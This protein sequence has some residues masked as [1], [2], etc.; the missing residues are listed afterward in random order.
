MLDKYTEAGVST[1]KADLLANNFKT[2]VSGEFSGSINLTGGPSLVATIDGIGTKFLIAH[3]LQ[4]YNGLGY[5][6]VNH[7]INDLLCS[8]QQVTPIA[9][10][11]YVASGNIDVDIVQ[12]IVKSMV[13]ACDENDMLLLGGETAEMPDVYMEGAYNIVGIAIGTIDKP[14]TLGGVQP[15]SLIVGL[16]SSGLHTNGY[17]L[18]R[19][20]FSENDFH[21]SFYGTKDFLG[22]KL[23]TPHRCYYPII[24]TLMVQCDI[25]AMAHITGG[26]FT[27]NLARII[28]EHLTVAL[29]N[30][31]EVPPIFDLIRDKGN[32]SKDEMYKVFNMGIGL[33]LIVGKDFD[34]SKI[35]NTGQ[36]IGVLKEK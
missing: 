20:I 35:G 36:I 24:K 28:P 27:G 13:A 1:D 17:S 18:I 5:D 29:T 7:C 22:K 34:I 2:L 3:Q 32:V 26:G 4:Q 21:K 30:T 10:L 12:T 11:D 33:V 25:L 19:S 6:I 15:G 8:G 14:F 16:Y 31:W 9:F 23:L